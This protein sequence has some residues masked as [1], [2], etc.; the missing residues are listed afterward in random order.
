MSH[1]QELSEDLLWGVTAIAVYIKRSQRQTYYLIERKKIPARK[2]GAK[3]IVARK[4]ELDQAL[5]ER[6]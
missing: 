4:S 2:L 1:S 6:R 5:G 3:I